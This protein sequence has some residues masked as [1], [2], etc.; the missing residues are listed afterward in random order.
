[1][2]WWLSDA[3]GQDLA[4]FKPLIRETLVLFKKIKKHGREKDS[5]KIVS[6][7][8]DAYSLLKIVF[9][10]LNTNYSVILI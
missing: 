8:H 4:S 2:M 7:K 3:A 6:K 1:M 5:N 9:L 10:L